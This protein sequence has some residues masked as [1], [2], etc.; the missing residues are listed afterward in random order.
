M[1]GLGV[2]ELVVI[3]LIVLLLFG[4]KRLPEAGAG[5]G[6][7]IRSFKDALSSPDENAKDVIDASSE[8]KQIKG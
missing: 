5:L 7:A 3:F 1:F 2:T 4:A 8:K 6:K